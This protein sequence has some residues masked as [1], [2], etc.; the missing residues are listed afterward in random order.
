MK[1][2]AKQRRTSESTESEDDK[3]NNVILQT[4]ILW[5]DFKTYTIDFDVMCDNY[6]DRFAMHLSEM[7]H[8]MQYSL[9]NQEK[10]NFEEGEPAIN[11]NMLQIAVK[12]RICIFDIG[13]DFN[14]LPRRTKEIKVFNA[15]SQFITPEA[16]VESGFNIVR[17][18]EDPTKTKDGFLVDRIT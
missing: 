14:D 2:K 1:E 3:T 12:D 8:N 10:V 9:N 13:E 15:T 11:E 18:Y 16:Y 5:K 6:D 4:K 7:P 17:S